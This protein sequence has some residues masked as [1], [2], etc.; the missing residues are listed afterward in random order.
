MGTVLGT[1]W[2]VWVMKCDWCV[3]EYDLEKLKEYDEDGHKWLLCTECLSTDNIYHKGLREFHRNLFEHKYHYSNKFKKKTL[4]RVCVKVGIKD[5][6][7]RVVIINTILKETKNF[8][9][10]EFVMKVSNVLNIKVPN[11]QGIFDIEYLK[12]YVFID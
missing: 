2:L 12:K 1:A 6:F 5:K 3:G 8:N 10:N 7:E 11:V 4:H 9:D